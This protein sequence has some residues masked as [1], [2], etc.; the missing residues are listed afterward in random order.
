MK[1]IRA[2]DQAITLWLSL[3]RQLVVKVA[4]RDLYPGLA[5]TMSFTSPMIL[6]RPVYSSTFYTPYKH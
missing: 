6:E 3:Q 5:L 2:I 4:L 1:I